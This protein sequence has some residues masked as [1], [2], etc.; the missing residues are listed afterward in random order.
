MRDL[1]QIMSYTGA[2][3]G[4]LILIGVTPVA[5]PLQ[6]S[7]QA[8]TNIYVGA[9]TGFSS[10]IGVLSRRQE[11]GPTVG[12]KIGYRIA[13]G[14]AVIAHTDIEMLEGT[15]VNRIDRS[16]AMRLIH[17]GIGA[18]RSIIRPS[19]GRWEVSAELGAGRTSMH[20][21]GVGS[22]MVVDRPFGLSCNSSFGGLTALTH[23]SRRTT[24]VVRSRI[25]WIMTKREQTEGLA[26]S[27]PFGSAY[28][29]PITVGIKMG[30]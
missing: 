13:D 5:N 12:V 23:P 22:A 28:T 29:L 17:A 27:V 7:A 14:W 2:R 20:T 3:I 30:F 1:G 6:P 15:F 10:P 8:Q 25:R 19:H 24:V 4:W 21:V 11:F 18:E 9:E 16:A 26:G